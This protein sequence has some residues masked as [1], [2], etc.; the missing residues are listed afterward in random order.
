MKTTCHLGFWLVYTFNKDNPLFQLIA[1]TW[2]RSTPSSQTT[3]QRAHRIVNE[4]ATAL[5]SV[6]RVQLTLRHQ[7]DS[8]LLT[9]PT[10]GGGSFS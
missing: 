1:L 4:G 10:G 2:N 9:S 6:C 5:E 7:Y 8:L 3:A